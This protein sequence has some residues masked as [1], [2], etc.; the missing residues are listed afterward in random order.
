MKYLQKQTAFWLEIVK[1]R[2]NVEDIDI[3]GRFIV[4]EGIRLLLFSSTECL[5]PVD[6]QGPGKKD[7][8]LFQN[9]IPT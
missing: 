6:C 9:T 4:R 7:C 2:D 5:S 8:L 3:D 1:E